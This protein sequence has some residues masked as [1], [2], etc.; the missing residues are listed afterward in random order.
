MVTD[1]GIAGKATVEWS[2]TMA[3]FSKEITSVPIVY[4]RPLVTVTGLADGIET[5]KPDI[6]EFVDENVSLLT[7]KVIFELRRLRG[8]RYPSVFRFGVFL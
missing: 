8:W 4:A 7:S 3:E 1:V 5:T 2:K 6:L